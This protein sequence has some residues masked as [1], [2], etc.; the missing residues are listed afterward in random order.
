MRVERIGD[1]TLYLGDCL[2]ILP[3]LDKV[4]A[5]VTSPP[6]DNLRDYGG[7]GFEWEPL[8]LPI[9]RSIKDGGVIVWNVSDAT[10]NGSETG[11][12]FRQA[13]AFKESGLNLHD[14]MIYISNSV[15][16]PMNTR[17]EMGFEYMFI[18]SNGAPSTF[19][20]LIDR[21]N[22]WAGT[23]M[24][25]TDRQPDGTTKQINGKGNVIKPHGKRFNWWFINN[26]TQ[27]T[28]HPAPMPFSMAHDHIVSWTNQGDTV[29]DWFMGGGTSGIAALQAGRK[30]IGIE[31]EEKYFDIACERITAAQA[32]GRLFE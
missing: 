1:A 14:T 23:V 15:N 8:V 3:T 32:Q 26:S 21:P 24:H 25:G 28:G 29:G 16:F 27:D 22:A 4:D 10:V 6:Y 17:Y 19:N 5:V 7:H 11:T 9:S 20:P 13:L 18:F 12:S 30:F 2:E 31:I